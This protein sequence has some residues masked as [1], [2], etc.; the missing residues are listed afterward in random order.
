MPYLGQEHNRKKRLEA[1]MNEL[2]NAV[3]TRKDWH[4]IQDLFYQN[5]GVR[6]DGEGAGWEG[7]DVLCKK[8]WPQDT[9]REH[10]YS[11]WLDVLV[12]RQ[13]KDVDENKFIEPENMMIHKK[14]W[15]A[16]IHDTIRDLRADLQRTFSDPLDAPCLKQTLRA[17]D[18]Y[19][20]FHMHSGD[21]KTISVE[22][23]QSTGNPYIVPLG[24]IAW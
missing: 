6:H 14:I 21:F 22:S 20:T 7:I 3:G 10:L 11:F 17:F 15:K 12:R 23:P 19:W 1:K 18:H 16:R 8:I 13:Y 5:V 2:F 9:E 4:Y 24:F